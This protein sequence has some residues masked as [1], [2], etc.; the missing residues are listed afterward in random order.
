MQ[1]D[2]IVDEL[3]RPVM[4]AIKRHVKDSDAKTDIYNRAYEAIMISME[5]NK[6][7]AEKAEHLLEMAQDSL[8]SYAEFYGKAVSLSELPEDCLPSEDSDLH[9][10]TRI[11]EWDYIKE[12]R[13]RAETAESS[14]AALREQTRWIPVGERLPLPAQKRDGYMSDSSELVHVYP[15]PKNDRAVCYLHYLEKWSCSAEVTP[16][17]W[18][19]IDLPEVE[20]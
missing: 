8:N 9:I 12:Q 17:H 6:S 19:P 3:M 13:E 18:R 10:L 2:Q 4:A 14:L 7:R 20:R 5:V 16:T 15:P 1:G 11:A